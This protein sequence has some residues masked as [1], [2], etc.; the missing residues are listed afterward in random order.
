MLELVDLQVLKLVVEYVELVV[1]ADNMLVEVG[2][3]V[4]QIIVFGR[5]LEF[6]RTS[7]LPLHLLLEVWYRPT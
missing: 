3:I 7:N 6:L 1:V 4:A 5:L 2:C